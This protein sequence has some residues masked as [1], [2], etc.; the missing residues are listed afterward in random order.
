[1]DVA[2]RLFYWD[3][4]RATGVDRVAREAGVAPTTL[5]RSFPSKDDLVA[6]YV[7]R[8]AARYRDWVDDLTGDRRR[9][10]AARILA[11]VEALTGNTGPETFRGCPF[12]M[13]L[14]EYPDPE[15]P[16]HA[17]AQSIKA[18]VR[19]KLRALTAELLPGVSART[20]AAVGDQLVLVIEGIY[21]SA[22]ALGPT[23]PVVQAR[24]L[25]KLVIES[26][27]K[28]AGVSS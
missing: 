25:A 27:T 11:L 3:G 7:D 19:Q 23:G 14:A 12:L 26:A 15:S 16:A 5:Y 1:L 4:I 6:A 22:A 18:W 20:R 8:Y 2:D 28:Q 13:V 9:P 17:S 24:A 10:P 21:A